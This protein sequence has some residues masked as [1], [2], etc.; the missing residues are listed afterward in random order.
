MYQNLKL[1]G[2]GGFADDYYTSDYWSSSEYDAPNAW[3]QYFANGNQYANYSKNLYERVR[4]VRAFWLE[5][6]L[7]FSLYLASFLVLMQVGILS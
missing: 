5:V 3:S 4:A 6:L 7:L 2:V 1:F